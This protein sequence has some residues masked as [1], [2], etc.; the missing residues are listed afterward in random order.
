MLVC[1]PTIYYNVPNTFSHPCTVNESHSK[2]PT[3]GGPEGAHEPLKNP[4]N[5][6][7]DCI[8]NFE[9]IRTETH[10]LHKDHNRTTDPIEC[11]SEKTRSDANGIIDVKAGDNT[12]SPK[13]LPKCAITSDLTKEPIG[14]DSIG[15]IEDETC[16]A[17]KVPKSETDDITGKGK[18]TDET[19]GEPR[20]GKHT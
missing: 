6:G 18:S 16:E 11:T 19:P 3:A 4:C 20:E 15:K 2:C 7:T 8:Y 12:T 10:A 5:E 14:H 13:V 1:L 17:R 9:P